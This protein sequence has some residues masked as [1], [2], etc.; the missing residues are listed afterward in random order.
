MIRAYWASTSFV[1]EQVGR[2]LDALERLHLQENTIVVFWGDHGY[3]LGEKGKWSKAYSLY[4]VGLRVPLI[5]VVPG[6]RAKVNTKVSERPVQLLDMYPTLAELCGL[7]RP[8]DNEGHSLVSLLRNPAAKWSYP[9]YS[10]TAYQG[11]LGKS[12]RTERW[13]N[14]QWDDGKSGE[15]LLD[16][17]NDPHELKN[18][19]ADPAYAKT[20]QEMRV[21]LARMPTR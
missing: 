18:L 3:H 16:Q 9:A 11:H 19:A 14:A 13:H 15:M 4:E 12:V 2:V 21:L 10:V 1:D 20:V 7:P 6:A 8:A 17:S 5:F